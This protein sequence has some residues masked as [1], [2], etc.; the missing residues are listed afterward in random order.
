MHNRHDKLQMSRA[1]WFRGNIDGGQNESAHRSDKQPPPENDTIGPAEEQRGGELRIM[2]ANSATNP[3]QPSP[4]TRT[5]HTGFQLSTQRQLSSLTDCLSKVVVQP[6]L[7]DLMDIMKE[8]LDVIQ[9]S[10]ISASM[11]GN[12][13]RSR[14]WGIYRKV[15]EKHDTEF[16]LLFSTVSTSFIVVME[17][18]LRPN[19]SDTTNALLTQLVQL[20]LSNLTAAGSTPAAPA[21]TWSP[22]SVNIKIQSIAYASL[23]MSLLAAFGAV[24]CKQ[25]LGYYESHRSGRSSQQERGKRRQEKFDGIIA[26]HFDAVIVLCASRSIAWVIIETTVFGFLFYSL[27]TPIS[28]ILRM[29]RIHGKIFLN[30]TP[31]GQI[32]LLVFPAADDV[33]CNGYP[34]PLDQVR[35]NCLKNIQRS[36]H[37]TDPMHAVDLFAQRYLH[38]LFN[39]CRSL[40]SSLC[41][42]VPHSPTEFGDSETQPVDQNL[43]VSIDNQRPLD[44]TFPD[45]P[46]NFLEAPSIK[47]L[48]KTSTDPDVVLA[49]LNLIPHVEWP[50]DL[51]IS[52]MVRLG[53]LASHLD[54]ADRHYIDGNVRIPR[55]TYD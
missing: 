27:T 8:V 24:L 49:V 20:G 7:S 2:G 9:N 28:T 23:S 26:W 52:S 10:T 4:A 29:L 41:S 47:W 21:S 12:D 36:F 44:L 53:K 22:S 30:S 35:P 45:I 34:V 18:K 40:V 25:W 50:M 5:S 19:P 46:A 33:C 42:L 38:P 17:S 39:A 13:S 54:L 32:D 16:L 43:D 14:F 55:A 31:N 15:T 1:C 3:E 51:D 37:F 6:N 48:L 11:G